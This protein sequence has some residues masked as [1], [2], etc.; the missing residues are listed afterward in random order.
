MSGVIK[1]WCVFCL[2]IF[3]GCNS[4]PALYDDYV[5]VNKWA[6]MALRIT[7]DTP[8]NSPTYASRCF[9]YIGLTKYESVVHGFSDYNSLSGQLIELDDL[10]KPDDDKPYN[11][12]I[13]FNAAQARIIKSVYNQTDDANKKRIDSLEVDVHN[14]I[15]AHIHDD[16]IISRSISFG[17]HIA[18]KIFEW[19]KSDGGHR[20]Y[21]R[22]FE[23]TLNH[24]TS[25]GSWKPPL[26]AQSFSHHPLHPTWGNNRCFVKQNQELPIPE[27]ITFN[28]DPNSDYFQ[29]FLNVYEQDKV[30]TQ[31]EKETAIWW[32]DDPDESFTPPG[33][34]YYITNIAVKSKQTNLIESA[35]AFARVGIAVSDAFVKCWKWK[36]HYL[37]WE[38]IFVYR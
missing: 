21:L 9:G 34:S 4:T 12:Q 35:S 33:H 25:V 22:N 3:G 30:L 1:I 18:D 11:W 14:N 16:K 37:F 2:F 10:P 17:Q 31:S 20:A 32:G 7:K 19:S 6:D 36:Y 8:A 28:S 5:I 15:S 23:K 13:S 24:P 29:E 38:R 27:M 26:Y